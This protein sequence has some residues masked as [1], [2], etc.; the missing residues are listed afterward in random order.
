[1]PWLARVFGLSDE[2]AM[3]LSGGKPLIFLL[4]ASASPS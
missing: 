4:A 2:T 1:M 3:S